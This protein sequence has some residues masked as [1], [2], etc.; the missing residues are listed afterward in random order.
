[1]FGSK[2]VEEYPTAK[3]CPFLF[4][5]TL[6]SNRGSNK[7]AMCIKEQCQVWDEQRKDCGLK[8]K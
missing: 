3:A 5:Q 1:M 4:T 6:P 7:F 8:Q 2:K